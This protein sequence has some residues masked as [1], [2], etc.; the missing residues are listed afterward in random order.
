MQ[1]HMMH[2]AYGY[3]LMLAGFNSDD[4]KHKKIQDWIGKFFKWNKKPD[5]VYMG[6]D[7]GYYWPGVLRGALENAPNY[8]IWNPK[9][10][11]TNATRELNKVVLEDGSI[12]DRT[13]RGNKALWYHHT[14]LIE[15]IITLEM[16]RKHSIKI[17][18]SLEQRFERAGEI[19]IQGFENHS[20]M[21]MEIH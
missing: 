1:M 7:L 16:A 10:L 2:M 11:L 4:P 9:K 6:L 17:P 15:T 8:S 20:Y 18:S 14:G 21:D 12:K 5:S 3:Y 19:F 13:T